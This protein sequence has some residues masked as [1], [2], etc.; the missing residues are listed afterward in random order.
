MPT[1]PRTV[2]EDVKR[3]AAENKGR[4]TLGLPTPWKTLN[5]KTS[6]FRAGMFWVL[7]GYTSSGKSTIANEMIYHL[8]ELGHRVVVFSL[9]MSTE[10]TMLRLAARHA[11]VSPLDVLLGRFDRNE[12]DLLEAAF[13]MMQSSGLVVYE[14]V[15]HLPDIQGAVIQELKRGPIGLVVIDFIQNL[16]GDGSIYERMSRAAIELQS[17]FKLQ[18]TCALV[19]SQLPNQ[20]VR[21]PS[22]VIA[23]KGAGEL[24]AAADVGLEIFIDQEHPDTIDLRIRKHR[25]G[26]TGSQRLKWNWSFTALEEVQDE[27]PE[28]SPDEP[29]GI[30]ETIP[31]FG[32][33]GAPA[34]ERQ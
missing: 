33:Q 19:L 13:D 10:T 26:P 8:L 22:Q 7:G 34:Q 5:R 9:E 12:A 29:V 3:Q 11:G 2:W 27:Q 15:V 16:Q 14:D 28:P 21:E 6:G 32:D 18:R 31:L 20:A 25:H 4:R 1:D 24:A 23:Y 17:F 30:D